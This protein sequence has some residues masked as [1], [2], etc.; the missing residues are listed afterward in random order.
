MIQYELFIVAGALSALIPVIL[1]LIHRQQAKHLPFSTLRFLRISVQKT[2]RRRRIH[3]VL[4]MLLR[5]AALC[6]IALGLSEIRITQLS[7]LLGRGASS[8]VAIILDNSASMAVR[9][10]GRPRFEIARGAAEQI[11][12]RLDPSDQVALFLTG[13]RPFDEQAR[14]DAPR[15][16]VLRMF[17]QSAVSYE[18]ADLAGRIEQ[19]RNLLAE[20]E[21]ANKV[22]YVLTDMQARSWEGL[23]QEGGPSGPADQPP[24]GKADRARQIPIVIVD[25]ARQAE[26]NAAI[27]EVKLE[28]AAPVAGLP[29]KAAVEVFNAASIPQQPRV[30]LYLDGASRSAS[31]ELSI[32]AQERTTH[33]FEFTLDRPGVYRGEVRLVGEDGSPVDDRRLFALEVQQAI[34]VAIVTASRHEIPY[35]DD[36]FYL[37]QALMLE[38]AGAGP[39]RC[40]LLTAGDLASEPLA[41]YTVIYCV[42]LQAPGAAAAEALRKYVEGG[43]HLFW[44]CGE[45]V[46]PAAYNAA[47]QNAQGQLLPAALLEVRTADP[48]Q[49]RDSWQIGFFDKTHRALARLAE[50]ASLYQP[51]L[52][53]KHVRL[54]ER[55]IPGAWV[56]ARLDDGQPLLVHRRVGRGSVTMLG[57]SV[58]KDWTNLPL[59][60]VFLPLVAGMTFELAGSQPGRHA[61]LAGSPLVLDFE[62][63]SGPLKVEVVPPSGVRYEL[64]PKAEPGQPGLVFRYTDTFDVGFYTLRPLGAAASRPVTFA[65][66]VDPDEADPT[67]LPREEL[68]QRLGQTDLVWAED[69]DDLS[70]TFRLLHEGTNLWDYFLWA[71]LIVLVFETFVSN[72]L[73][74]RTAD[75]PVGDA[76]PGPRRLARKGAAA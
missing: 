53:Y 64:S 14:L 62:E 40:T 1:H 15:D 63:Q 18:R 29:V 57:T 46:E 68:Q 37:Q 74:P 60:T 28:V 71:V 31:P 65:V 69:P 25:C 36:G 22:I 11:L 58:Q 27:Q 50:P 9:D 32:P 19:A 61:V 66:N 17:N 39:I 72:R 59:K 45:N 51:V 30:E 16:A 2:R 67:R 76:V 7:R 12:N 42:N 13:G 43:G 48:V 49:G 34:P 54:D 55:T 23:K 52:I 20:S 38:Q 5:A 6:L 10:Q 47:N 56:L 3:D 41:G 73:S 26:P 21:A 44:T 35:L 4:L 70:G 33:V 75:E 8:A 24:D